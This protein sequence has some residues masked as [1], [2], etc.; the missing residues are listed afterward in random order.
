M[1]RTRRPRSDRECIYMFMYLPLLASLMA[2]SLLVAEIEE[3]KAEVNRLRQ[4]HL[5]QK[6]QQMQAQTAFQL[7]WGTG[8]DQQMVN[9]NLNQRRMGEIVYANST[10]GKIS[11]LNN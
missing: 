10:Q 3:N 9:P 8:I 4:L 1:V 2:I 7:D 11:S 5:H 6:Q